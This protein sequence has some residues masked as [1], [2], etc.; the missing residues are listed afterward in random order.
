[1]ERYNPR[2][3]GFRLIRDRCNPAEIA[4]H[5]PMLATR[6]HD[7]VSGDEVDPLRTLRGQPDELHED[8]SYHH[9]M[10]V[11]RFNRALRAG[12]GFR[13]SGDE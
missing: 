7:E 10:N 1:M 8:E 11:E 9:D 6:I 4:G 12:H 5:R 3:G 2:P 13:N